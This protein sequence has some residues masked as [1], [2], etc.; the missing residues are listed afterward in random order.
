VGLVSSEVM[1]QSL[2]NFHYK[3]NT[4]TSTLP[5]QGSLFAFPGSNYKTNEEEQSF[6][7]NL[8]LQE[9]KQIYI[10]LEINWWEGG[11]LAKEFTWHHRARIS[12][13]RDRRNT[14]SHSH[15]NLRD[16]QKESDTSST[17]NVRIAVSDA[18]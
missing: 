13:A 6:S 8:E 1:K 18:S 15:I 9:P 7:T 3:T 2:T 5:E 4:W 11:P 14:R 12:K 10:F 16:H 17:I